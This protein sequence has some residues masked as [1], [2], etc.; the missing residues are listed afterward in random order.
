MA[1]VL[2]Q[3]VTLNESILKKTDITFETETTTCQRY[4]V[5]VKSCIVQLFIFNEFKRQK[6]IR[7]RVKE[8]TEKGKVHYS[9]E[10][11]GKEALE[12]KITY[13]KKHHNSIEFHTVHSTII[14]DVCLLYCTPKQC[15]SNRSMYLNARLMHSNSHLSNTTSFS[16]KILHSSTE[17]EE[18]CE[19]RISPKTLRSVCF[20]VYCLSIKS[21]VCTFLFIIFDFQKCFWLHCMS[22]FV[23]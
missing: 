6:C 23:R 13:V 1:N 3:C 2:W 21:N 16:H 17:L 4:S 22:H 15:Y 7:N 18:G 10:W 5:F 14:I 11:I 8:W 9:I 20:S 12:Q 19:G